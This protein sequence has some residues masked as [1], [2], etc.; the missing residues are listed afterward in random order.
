MMALGTLDRTPPPFFRQGPSALT[1][2]TFCSALALFLMV[3]DTRFSITQPLRAAV[4]DRAATRCSAC[5]GRSRRGATARDYL[6]GAAAA[7]WRR[8]GGAQRA[9]AAVRARRPGRAAAAENT[10]L[11]EAARAAAE[12]WTCASQAAE[13]L[14]E[15]ADP[16][17]RK[18]DHRPRLDATASRS[19]RR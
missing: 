19:A 13:V 8:G 17:S 11:R 18:V 3:A 9:G 2:L 16:Y 14:Y 4:G 5:C 10:R 1:K 15:A 7:R 12:R 6:G